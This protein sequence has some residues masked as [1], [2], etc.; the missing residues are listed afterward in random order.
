MLRTT[1]APQIQYIAPPWISFFRRPRSPPFLKI[2]SLLRGHHY[3]NFNNWVKSLIWTDVFLF[4]LYTCKSL[5]ECGWVEF[6]PCKKYFSELPEWSEFL[7]K[8]TRHRQTFSCDFSVGWILPH[9]YSSIVLRFAYILYQQTTNVWVIHL[10][11]GG[12]HINIY[13][14]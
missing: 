1:G 8:R 6:S 13:T 3:D 9:F 2:H 4:V 5:K 12:I 14:A 7:S 10:I 11:W